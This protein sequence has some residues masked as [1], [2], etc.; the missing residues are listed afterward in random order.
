LAGLGLLGAEGLHLATPRLCTAAAGGD[1][2]NWGANTKR[3][4]PLRLRRGVI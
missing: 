1:A 4:I 2:G 3:E